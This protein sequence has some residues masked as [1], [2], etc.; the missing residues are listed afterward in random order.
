[1]LSQNFDVLEKLVRSMIEYDV[2]VG[3]A[4]SMKNERV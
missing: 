3:D 2:H 1:M 4:K